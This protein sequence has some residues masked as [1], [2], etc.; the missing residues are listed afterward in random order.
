MQKLE[1]LIR[2][3]L[4]REGDREKMDALLQAALDYRHAHSGPPF[5][6]LLAGLE[7]HRLMVRAARVAN[8]PP[9]ERERIA[10]EQKTALS[11]LTPKH[12]VRIA[13]EQILG[14]T[15][16]DENTTLLTGAKLASAEELRYQAGRA[17]MAA[18]V[19]AGLSG[20][21]PREE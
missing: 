11:V 5:D 8:L 12:P 15:L 7:A 16:A 14:D 1:Q 18:D 19:L 2:Q 4:V 17:A 9:K 20:L 21:W 13:L 6:P 3:A 10:E